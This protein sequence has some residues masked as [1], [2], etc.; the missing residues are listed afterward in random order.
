MAC[1]PDPPQAEGPRDGREAANPQAEGPRDGREAANPQAEGPRDGREAANPQAEA[2]SM[3]LGVF[4]MA[5][6]VS[7]KH[8]TKL[9]IFTRWEK[10]PYDSAGLRKA[11]DAFRR[12]TRKLPYAADVI[13]MRLGMITEACKDLR[14]DLAWLDLAGQRRVEEFTLRTQTEIIG[15]MNTLP[16]TAE[17][18]S[19][20][21]TDYKAKLKAA[22]AP[23][24]ATDLLL[25]RV[26]R[27]AQDLC[28]CISELNK[29]TSAACV[30]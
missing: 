11:A 2:G 17:G 8:E 5:M 6:Y 19:H 7:G 3:T 27:I 4:T 24:A 9:N 14:C 20:S 29:A 10:L 1:P 30:K 16:F 23:S 12:E 26:D 21:V 15:R 13:K 18:L 28:D 22:A 25:A